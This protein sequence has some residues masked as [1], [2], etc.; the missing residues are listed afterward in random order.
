MR[1]SAVRSCQW[2]ESRRVFLFLGWMKRVGRRD[3]GEGD[4]ERRWTC[5]AE[6]RHL[7][8][9]SGFAGRHVQAQWGASTE[10]IEQ[11]ILGWLSGGTTIFME[12]E[13]EVGWEWSCGGC[14]DLCGGSIIQNSAD[15]YRHDPGRRSTIGTC[16]STD[17]N[18]DRTSRRGLGSSTLSTEPIR[19]RAA[20]NETRTIEAEAEHTEN[21]Q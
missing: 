14:R 19:D 10:S 17:K 11:L 12:V 3:A 4:G 20:D 18:W 13:S 15:H 7:G 6:W 1:R 8:H 21:K 16:R 5:S 2:S 9:E